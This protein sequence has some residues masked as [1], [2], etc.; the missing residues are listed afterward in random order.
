M[1]RLKARAFER[2]RRPTSFERKSPAFGKVSRHVTRTNA[3]DG[4]VRKG[5]ATARVLSYT[6]PEHF[7]NTPLHA[8]SRRRVYVEFKSSG[9]P[10]PVCLYT[11]GRNRSSFSNEA[12]EAPS[13]TLRR[14]SVFHKV[15]V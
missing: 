13:A 8:S 12:V 6:G 11:E 14:L 7:Y 3:V 10:D 1:L 15:F 5:H 2:S 9:R 4:G